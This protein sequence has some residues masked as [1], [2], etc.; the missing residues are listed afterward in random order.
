MSIDATDS[1][2]LSTS[3]AGCADLKRV[4]LVRRTIGAVGV[5][6]PALAV[7]VAN[8]SILVFHISIQNAL[9]P[10]SFSKGCSHCRRSSASYLERDIGTTGQPGW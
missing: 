8:A 4:V 6:A 10:V 5:G 9:H 2:V 7:K 1:L 3:V